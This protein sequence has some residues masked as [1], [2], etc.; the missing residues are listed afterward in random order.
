MLIGQNA[1]EFKTNELI[2]EERPNNN[3]IGYDLKISY[4]KSIDY[5]T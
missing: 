5:P 2:K 3:I 1:N 4:T